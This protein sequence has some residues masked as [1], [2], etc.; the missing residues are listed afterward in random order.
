MSNKAGVRIFGA[1]GGPWSPE[2]NIIAGTSNLLPGHS[3]HITCVL[4]TEK[5]ELSI[6][7]GQKIFFLTPKIFLGHQKKEEGEIFLKFFFLKSV[8]YYVNIYY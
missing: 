1:I 7:C 8:H 5:C 2:I 3:K 4:N 6:N